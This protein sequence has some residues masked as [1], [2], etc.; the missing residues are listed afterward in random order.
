MSDSVLSI[1]DLHLSFPIFRGDI[2]ALDR[3]S[4]V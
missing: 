1:E 3:K 2:H 4:V